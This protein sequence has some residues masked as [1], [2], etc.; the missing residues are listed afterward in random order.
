MSAPAFEPQ[1]SRAYLKIKQVHDYLKVDRW[2]RSYT[3]TKHHFNILFIQGIIQNFYKIQ[4]LIENSSKYLFVGFCKK[5]K[6]MNTCGLRVTYSCPLMI[7]MLVK[8]V[9]EFIGCIHSDW[10]WKQSKI[11]LKFAF[12]QAQKIMSTGIC[13]VI[14]KFQQISTFSWSWQCVKLICKF[15]PLLEL[16]SHCAVNAVYFNVNI[17]GNFRSV[18][19]LLSKMCFKDKISSV[20]KL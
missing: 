6:N 4:C 11:A 14:R 7:L 18:Y 13:R 20:I 3:N 9:D 12:I 16:C 1:V 10:G 19:L 5:N 15:S 17:R 2:R 8:L